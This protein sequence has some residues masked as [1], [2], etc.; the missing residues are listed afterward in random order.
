[1]PGGN[2][3][4]FAGGTD[5]GRETNVWQLIEDASEPLPEPPVELLDTE[6]VLD[7]VERATAALLFRRDRQGMLRQAMRVL[8]DDWRTAMATARLREQLDRQ[9]ARL[10]AKA[11]GTYWGERDGH[12]VATQPTH[13]VVDRH[14]WERAK[15]DAREAGMTLGELLGQLVARAGRG[16]QRAPAPVHADGLA[17]TG[18]QARLFARVAVTKGSWSAFV[19]RA[20]HERVSVARYLGL[21][22]EA[23][24]RTYDGT[25]NE[26]R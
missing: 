17:V 8:E 5:A 7:W 6:A 20:H 10:I 23:S 9:Q 12:R 24:G 26:R 18:D 1:M 4:N 21:V 25:G 2:N 19:Q 3:G 13:V 22:V 14:A 15:Q 16:D 11:R